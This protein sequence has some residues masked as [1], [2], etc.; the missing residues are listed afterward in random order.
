[1]KDL[2]VIDKTWTLF[3]DRD[4]VINYEKENEYVNKWED[5]RFYEGAKEA[6]KKFTQK[7]GL[8]LI[9]TN[10]RGVGRGITRL[11]DLELMNENLLKEVAS[12]GG[13]ISKIFFCTDT[14]ETSPNR[15]PNT[16]MGLQAQREFPQ[17]VFLKT[18]MI[19][20]TKGDMEFGRNLGV[21]INVFIPSKYPVSQL[22]DGVYD[23]VFPDLIS[24]ANAL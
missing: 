12:N 23:M 10:Q 20:N 5:F 2:K 11:E 8:V 13:K 17:I 22:P 18:M 21:A 9:I 14:D 6:I 1:M 7:F 3:L 16:G 24:I 15:K 19:G 4:G